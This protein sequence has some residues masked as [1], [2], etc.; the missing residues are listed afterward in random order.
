MSEECRLSVGIMAFMSLNSC[1]R[2]KVRT[3][4]ILTLSIPC[5][6]S[7]YIGCATHTFALFSG[8]AILTYNLYAFDIV[9]MN[10]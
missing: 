5:S 8:V 9:H 6:A 3:L 7:L 4:F 2:Q 1:G 10:F